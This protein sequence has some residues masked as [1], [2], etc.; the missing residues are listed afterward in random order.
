MNHD[1]AHC[2]DYTKDCPKE[3]FRAEL[4]R[5]I[6]ENRSMFIGVPLAYSHIRDTEECKLV[7]EK[8]MDDTISRKAAIDVMN[9]LPK[10]IDEISGVSL[11]YS[12]V[13]SALGDTEK[14]PSA[15]RW[16]PISEGPP[17]ANGR[18]LVTR[19]LNACGA[20]WNR[21]YIINYS[22]LMGLKS[23]RIWWDGNVGKSDFEEITDVLAWKPSPKP[24]REKDYYE[25]E[26]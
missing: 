4:Q 24:W 19:G 11:D 14:L 12:D 22:D 5:D 25:Q 21:V 23:K 8:K 3:C 7:K 2:I 1:Y 6:E 17:K 10:W 26:R 15:Q 9:N 18:Y 20:L 16:I 13:I